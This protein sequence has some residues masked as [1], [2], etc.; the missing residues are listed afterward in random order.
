VSTVARVALS[1]PPTLEIAHVLF[2][3]I[4]AYSQLPM[5]RQHRVGR[6]LQELAKSTR[7]F[8]RA[9]SADQLLALPTGDGMALVF[10]GDPEAPVRNAVELSRALRDHPDL[11]LRMGIHSG[12]VFRIS[13]I[14]AASNV[15]GGGINMA[16]RVM[17]CGDAGHILLSKVMADVIAQ[18]G[19]W[20]DFKLQDLGEAEVK[21]GVR[22]HIYNLYSDAAGNAQLPQKLE[23]ARHAAVA[24]RSKLEPPYGIILKGLQTGAVVP[25]LGADACKVGRCVGGLLHPLSGADLAENLAVQARF[26]SADPRDRKELAKVSSYYVDVSGRP[27][28]R[29]HLRSMLLNPQYACN[30]LYKLLARIANRAVV[31][32][33]N[34]DTLLEKALGEEGKEYDVVVYP[35]DNAEYANGVLWWKHGEAKPSKLKANEIDIDEIGVRTLIYKIHGTVSINSAQWDSFVITEEDCI[36]MLSRIRN[37]IP[38]AFRTHFSERP[39]LFLGLGLQDW[40]SRVLLKELRASGMKSW[41]ICT[42]ATPFEK[43]LWNNRDVNVY[44]LRLEDFAAELQKESERP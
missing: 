6:E 17:D 1:T 25:F 12:P 34:Y 5:D 3:D 23:A 27:M 24:E 10:F 26:P 31:V 28:L 40:N 44:D 19:S 2:M 35:G 41:A 4:V 22:L 36:K 11:R 21:H 8:A 7:E 29:A 30:E 38:S 20:S 32:T 33:T 16:Q 37:A 9:Q 13:D 18:V 42:D 14:N 15:A 43:T 39:F